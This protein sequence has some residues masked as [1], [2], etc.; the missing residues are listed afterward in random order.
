MYLSLKIILADMMNF[1]YTFINHES[2][3]YL[4]ELDKKILLFRS[5]LTPAK[6]QKESLWGTPPLS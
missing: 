2:P 4:S 6:S 3:P 5:H 1:Y